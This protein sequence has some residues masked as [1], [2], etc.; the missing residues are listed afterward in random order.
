MSLKCVACMRG[1][2]PSERGKGQSVLNCTECF[3][4]LRRR[5]ALLPV[6]LF[7][8]GRGPI[9]FPRLLADAYLRLQS[10]SGL[11]FT[12]FVNFTDNDLVTPCAAERS[13][14]LVLTR[15]PRTAKDDG[16]FNVTVRLSFPSRFG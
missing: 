4:V 9:S 12:I 13:L 5:A 15:K 16:G 1:L 11:R 7:G 6:F 14:L 8:R 10:K 2:L 3:I